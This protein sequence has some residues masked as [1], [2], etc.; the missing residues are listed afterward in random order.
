MIL[1]IVTPNIRVIKQERKYFN[2]IVKAY[3]VFNKTFSNKFSI[4]LYRNNENKKIAVPIKKSIIAIYNHIH[5][6]Y[7]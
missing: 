1:P 7:I 5:L 2:L 3:C 4:T 6:I